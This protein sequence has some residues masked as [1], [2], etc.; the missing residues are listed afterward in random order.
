MDVL[1]CCCNDGDRD[2]GFGP[3]L[4]EQYGLMDDDPADLR[5]REFELRC[6]PAYD[7]QGDFQDQGRTVYLC[8]YLMPWCIARLLSKLGL[9]CGLRLSTGGLP[10]WLMGTRTGRRWL[11]TLLLLVLLVLVGWAAYSR[12]RQVR[13]VLNSPCYVCNP[14]RLDLEDRWWEADSQ[15]HGSTA[16][17]QALDRYA[18]YAHGPQCALDD[19]WI[20]ALEHNSTERWDRYLEVHRRVRRSG[21]KP[22]G[23]WARYDLL[24]G[25]A[26]PPPRPRKPQTGSGK[27]EDW[28]NALPR[29]YVVGC[30]G[31]GTTSLGHYLDAHPDLVV[32]H[33]TPPVALSSKKSNKKDPAS[34][35]VTLSPA[36]PW[37]DHFFAS[38]AD[39]TSDELRSWMRRGWGPPTLRDHQG[40]GA[41]RVEL[42]PDYLWL[43]SSRAASA[44]H[45][46][47]SPIAPRFLVLLADPVRL[48]REAHSRAV[49]AGVE[50]RT[51][52]A[53]VIRQELPRLARCLWWDQADPAEQR[54]RLVSGLC[55]AVS[56]EP[57]RL[58]PP[59]LWR[60]LLAPFLAHWMQQATPGDRRRWYFV[61]SEDL[62]QQPNRTLNRIA[63]DFLGLKAWDYGPWVRRVWHPEPQATRAL[64]PGAPWR[65]SWKAY[66]PRTEYLRR[67]RK[68]VS[69]TL[70]DAAGRAMRKVVPGLETALE[71]REKLRRLHCRLAGF[72][73][74][75]IIATQRCLGEGGAK[76]TM[77]KDKDLSKEDLEA[78]REQEAE[79]A[80]RDFYAPFQAQLMSMVEAVEELR[81]QRR[82]GGSAGADDDAPHQGDA[83]LRAFYLQQNRGHRNVQS[84]PKTKRPKPQQNKKKTTLKKRKK[85]Q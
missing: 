64:A 33:T 63:V 83:D 8:R 23:P 57:G 35:S 20:G 40:R 13:A 44:I 1:C 72:V 11:F 59:Y 66:L 48:V 2:S 3:A 58:G 50:D 51:S 5:E 12:G 26:A 46:T 77:A 10:G 29:L 18:R 28:R 82:S 69:D 24:L 65:N 79:A 36:T 15:H 52:L 7:D 73:D 68:R 76:K 56:G 45:R 17:T 75:D 84:K 21:S 22:L 34:N 30:R 71:T 78:Q 16:A 43:A 19:G 25:H 14:K 85:P 70:L 47:R 61:R 27:P 4:R 54:E 53:Q 9:D 37:D 42:G 41:L 74:T 39:W 31:A 60:G 81:S 49:D 62:M 67:A 38:V 32:R 6:W 55:G 80:L